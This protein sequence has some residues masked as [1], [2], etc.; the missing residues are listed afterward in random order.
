MLK[1]KITLAVWIVILL[2]SCSSKKEI[3]KTTQSEKTKQELTEK[4]DTKENT[5]VKI[6]ST[7]AETTEATVIIY[8]TDKS[9]DKTGKYPIKEIAVYKT[10]KTA[11]KTEARK[12]EAE[13]QIVKEEEVSQKSTKEGTKVTQI[14]RNHPGTKAIIIT[15]IL[16]TIAA[17]LFY[18]FKRPGST[19]ALKIGK[20]ATR[21]LG[22]IAGLFKTK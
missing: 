1:N 22:L 7:G 13:K 19:I 9:P 5:M 4:T 11:K 15:T 12:T 6:D 18:I 3:V 20:I 17:F 16:L 8:D 10:T 2:T 14:K 21:L